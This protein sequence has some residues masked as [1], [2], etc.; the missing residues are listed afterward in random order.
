MANNYDSDGETLVDDDR[1]RRRRRP[2]ERARSRSADTRRTRQS[3]YSER[4][5]SQKQG[6]SSKYET[7]GK[8]ALVLG[9]IQLIGGIYHLYHEEK[10]REKEREYRRHQR[11]AFERAKEKRRREEEKRELDDDYD[12]DSENEFLR[13]REVRRIT[14]GPARSHSSSSSR[15]RSRH[16]R[17]IDRAHSRSDRA[18]RRDS[19][20]GSRYERD[21][22]EPSRMR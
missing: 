20:A 21:R 1:Y 6:S 19:V 18:S 14:D 5:G 10:S 9:V 12:D 7:I 22:R 3:Y 4:S 11:R 13:P 15:S 8:V 17:K 16:E 2:Q